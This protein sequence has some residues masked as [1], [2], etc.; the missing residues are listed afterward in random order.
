MPVEARIADIDLAALSAGRTY[1]PSPTAWEDE[2]LYFLMLDRFSDGRER[3]YLANDGTAVAAS[4]VA[5]T[6]AFTDADA[7]NTTA[8]GPPRLFHA[9]R[10]MHGAADWPRSLGQ[11][12]LQS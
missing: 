8:R 11:A 5:T 2:I 4:A 1:H 7:A 9:D 3:D 12:A 6:P 10:W